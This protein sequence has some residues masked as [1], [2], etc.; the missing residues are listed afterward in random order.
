MISKPQLS[1]LPSRAIDEIFRTSTILASHIAEITLEVQKLFQISAYIEDRISLLPGYTNF[2]AKNLRAE[3]TVKNLGI[4][5]DT[6]LAVDVDSCHPSAALAVL[7]ALFG[8]GKDLYSASPADLEAPTWTD[9]RG[10][11][12]SD[13]VRITVAVLWSRFPE[14]FETMEVIP[15]IFVND[16][17]LLR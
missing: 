1:L 16:R 9:G 2:I 7:K 11:S 6:L 13:K 17:L 10:R 4:I 15:F 5:I 12:L 3:E 8:I 14:D